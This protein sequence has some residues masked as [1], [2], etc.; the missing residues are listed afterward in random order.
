MNTST[1]DRQS[2][3]KLFESSNHQSDVLIGLYKMVIPNWDNIK[4]LKG[5]PSINENTWQEICKLFIKFDHKYHP[6]CLAGG[7]WMNRGFSIENQLGDWQYYPIESDKIVY[8]WESNRITDVFISN[9]K[10]YGSGITVYFH[11][12][13]GESKSYWNVTQS[14]YR[15]LGRLLS[16]RKSIVL[17]S[18]VGHWIINK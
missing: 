17:P 13:I 14:S 10:R 12:L 2:V 7:C 5:W 6:D 9:N 4:K 8:N 16:Y 1:L 3:Y 15:R 18:R 11:R